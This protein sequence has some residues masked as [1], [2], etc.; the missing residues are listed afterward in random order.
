MCSVHVT[1]AADS[2]RIKL[3]NET[4][5]KRCDVTQFETGSALQNTINGNGKFTR[6]SSG[7]L[8]FKVLLVDICQ[9]VPYVCRRLNF[10]NA[11]LFTY[12]D[13]DKMVSV[14]L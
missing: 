14:I 6:L 10:L 7:F 9:K 5:G 1:L 13:I 8:L 11:V 12:S 2:D 3:I 4:W